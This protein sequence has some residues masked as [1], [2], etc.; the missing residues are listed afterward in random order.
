M[1]VANYQN[2]AS[3]LLT[4]TEKEN[5]KLH[6]QE[7]KSALNEIRSMIKN[8][9]DAAGFDAYSLNTNYVVLTKE[10]PLFWIAHTCIGEYSKQFSRRNSEIIQ[11]S[12]GYKL[13][14]GQKPTDT[15]ISG[16]TVRKGFQV[17]AVKKLESIFETLDEKYPRRITKTMS[18]DDVRAIHKY[19]K[20]RGF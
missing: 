19:L 16:N 3:M 13:I 10:S 7:K 15:E 5:M 9:I 4:D 1:G 11:S 12:N 17:A 6:Y 8:E 18:I 14:V 20:K 2:N